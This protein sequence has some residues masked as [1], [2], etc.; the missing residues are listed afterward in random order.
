MKKKFTLWHI[1]ALVFAV[2]SMVLLTLCI[3]TDI[4]YKLF[5]P[6]A[7]GFALVANVMNIVIMSRANKKSGQSEHSDDAEA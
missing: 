4:S 1:I 2:V 6:L 5:L 7:L 3:A